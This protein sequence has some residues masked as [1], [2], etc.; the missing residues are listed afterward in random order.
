MRIAAAIILIVVGAGGGVH[1]QVGGNSVYGQSGGRGTAQQ[2]EMMK[3]Q[4]SWEMMP[5]SDSSMFVDANIL[6]NVK[7]DEFVATFGVAEEADTAD[8]CRVKMGATIAGFAAALRDAGVQPEAT[9][10][11]FAAQTK[12]YGYRMEGNLAREQLV[13][14]E[15]KKTMAIRY[16]DK[17]RIDRFVEIAGRSK[18]YDLIKVDDVVTDVEAVGD[19]LAE[20]AASVVQAKVARHER[21]LGIKLRA[22]AQVYADRSSAYYP[23]EMY[24]SYA[25]GESENVTG[26]PE[27]S[28]T[29]VQ[30]LRKSRTFFFNPLNADGF[31]R[32]VDPVVLEPVVQFTL[33][34]KLRYEIEPRR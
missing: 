3:R 25:S 29:T 22:V 17:N 20:A 30:S 4:L 8:A 33:Y 13:G 14:F 19:R 24:D 15:L 31:D 28:Q 21:T 2:R 7:A 9:F 12:I 34:L 18:I 16:R 32:V 5:P 1:A 27:R 26:G 23:T 10:V 11:D 6:I